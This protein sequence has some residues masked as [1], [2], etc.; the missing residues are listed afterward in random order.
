MK[1]LFHFSK[2]F[3]I[4]ISVVFLFQSINPAQVSAQNGFTD[5][6]TLPI[7]STRFT[8]LAVDRY[9]SGFTQDGRTPKTL[10]IWNNSSDTVFIAMND[11]NGYA[12]TSNSG[13]RFILKNSAKNFP[14]LPTTKVWLKGNS[15]TTIRYELQYGGGDYPD[16]T[17]GA[18]FQNGGSVNGN[19]TIIDTT[20]TNV[21]TGTG[22]NPNSITFTPS[23]IIFNQYFNTTGFGVLYNPTGEILFRSGANN[24]VANNADIW[25][26]RTLGTVN[27]GRY[28][29]QAA[30][31]GAIQLFPRLGNPYQLALYSTGLKTGNVKGIGIHL[32]SGTSYAT[33]KGINGAATFNFV[34]TLLNNG[35]PVGSTSGNTFDTVKAAYFQNATG[36]DMIISTQGGENITVLAGNDAAIVGQVTATLQSNGSDVLVTA[37]NGTATVSANAAVNITADDIS[38]TAADVLDLNAGTVNVYGEEI[39]SI[40]TNNYFIN[41]APSTFQKWTH[42]FQLLDT[43]RI[44]IAAGVNYTG[45]P[46]FVPLDLYLVLK[47]LDG[48]VFT[49]MP[50]ISVG[51]N[52]PDYDNIVAPTILTGLTA[53]HKIATGFSL[54]KTDELKGAVWLRVVTAGSGVGLVNAPADVIF[55]GMK[56]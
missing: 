44:E 28:T 15:A 40:M 24:P 31:S 7:F 52:S 48:G 1:Q 14:M 47:S 56:F 20:K 43:G 41:N 42:G 25:L 4:L 39:V 3:L 19:L 9:I 45:E 16:Q 18:N 35:A 27:L 21:I 10:K 38:V 50:T 5:A 6:G 46:Y 51:T 29:S 11:K 2:F 32:D 26:N 8:S 13:L 23:G 54:I 36:N 55:Q 22:T 17:E 49:V 12:D 37:P 34:G 33:F 30:D 53:V